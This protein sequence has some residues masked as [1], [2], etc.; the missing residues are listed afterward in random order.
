MAQSM[1]TTPVTAGSDTIPFWDRDLEV[2]GQTQ[3]NAVGRNVSQLTE[4]V[5]HS[6]LQFHKTGL[7]PINSADEE[8][9]NLMDSNAL[10]YSNAYGIVDEHSSLLRHGRDVSPSGGF[11]EP[12]LRHKPPQLDLE[13]LTA[14]VLQ[15]LRSIPAVLLA[16]VLNLLDAMSYGIIIFPASDGR[17]PA[18]AAQSGISMFLA[19]TVISQIVFTFGGSRF[20]GAVG[21]MM[22]EVMP[23]LHIICA[24]IESKMPDSGTHEVTATIMAAYS[25][26]AIL[27]GLVFL[28]LGLFKLGNLIQFFPRH[29]LVG[30]IG[31]IGVFL[32]ITGIE[33]TAH[34]EPRLLSKQYYVDIFKFD[35]FK[36]WGSSFAVAIVL[37]VIQRFT[38]HPLLVPLFYAI[39]PLIFYGVV[40]SAGMSLESLRKDGWLFDLPSSGE[41]PF[42]TFWQYV[43]VGAIDWSALA[44]TIPTQLALAFFGILHVPINLPALAISTGQEV[45]LSWEIVGHG[46]SNIVAGLFSTPQN[47]LVYSNSLLYIR[48]GGDSFVS[49]CLLIAANVFLW[50][51]GGSLIAYVPSIVVGALIF[52]LGM[53]LFID[54]V[55]HTW[56]VGIHPLEYATI[57]SIVLSMALIGFTEG[58]VVG[59]VLACV[60]FVVIYSQRSIIRDSFSGS[61]L[62]STVHRLYRQQLFLDNCGSQ[63]HI[64]KLQGFVFFGTAN[65]LEVYVQNLLADDAS[66]RFFVMDFSLI[67]GVDYSSLEYF[68]RIKRLLVSH[69]THLVL[70]SLQDLEKDVGKSGIFNSDS[71]HGVEDDDCDEFVHQFFTLNEALE[72]SEN[73]LLKVY[74]TRLNR[75]NASK[76]LPVP[77]DPLGSANSALFT[78][79]PRNMHLQHAASYVMKEHP[80]EHRKSVARPISVL[81]Q[82]F[83]EIS[84]FENVLAELYE[85]S[86]E[87]VEVTEGTVLY[88]VGDLATE[89]YVIEEGE[90]IV[91][92]PNGGA[93]ERVIETLLPGTMV[94]E[95]ELFCDRPR[96]C[97]LS[98]ASNCILWKLCKFTFDELSKT[99]PDLMLKF[100]TKVALP[101]DSVR[102]YNTI[103]HWSQK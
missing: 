6:I 50:I 15:G 40:A 29:I 67:N 98:A 3:S 18:T 101:F 76:S 78:E 44:A 14:L 95:L 5:S 7:P 70:C 65:Q 94:G 81:L 9:D 90:L 93:Q 39:V 61:Q 103:R 20:R 55:I 77:V 21:S 54:S 82:A 85:T 36:L 2:A 26:S 42:Y 63:I 25:L 37:K 8:E 75:E 91:S 19:S 24:V 41:A 38:S 10:S 84:G 53:D 43:D 12:H 86:F 59:L 99:H 80:F 28:L 4:Q 69:N 46:L 96:T 31:G 49:G 27:T 52:H 17:L 32:I 66:V 92:L 16:V 83:A 102:L 71:E 34:V 11:A 89:L 45:D 57:I 87:S 88:D 13:T 51:K 22:I 97:R 100:V 30:C 1:R 23:F 58:V 64:L 74:Y 73:E 72:W 56:F 47:Y 79:T 68:N 60:F 48:S 35:A 62:R 33:V